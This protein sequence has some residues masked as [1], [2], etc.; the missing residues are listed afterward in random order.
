MS[1]PLSQWGHCNAVLSSHTPSLRWKACPLIYDYDAVK[2]IRPAEPQSLP[3]VSAL[4]CDEVEADKAAHGVGDQHRWLATIRLDCMLDQRPQLVKVP[5]LQ[6]TR[7]CTS[8]LYSWSHP[9][10]L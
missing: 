2:T 4:S 7:G 10:L 8:V 1:N 5:R 9:R 6:T 3:P